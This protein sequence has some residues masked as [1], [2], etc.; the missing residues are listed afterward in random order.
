MDIKGKGLWLSRG[1]VFLL[2][3]CIVRVHEIMTT[4]GGGAVIRTLSVAKREKVVANG[5][6]A[7]VGLEMSVSQ[8]LDPR[9]LVQGVHLE[10]TVDEFMEELFAM[11]EDVSLAV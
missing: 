9:V 4:R 6:F 5:K 7:E 1:M 8:K 2:T 3:R 10:Q 11:N